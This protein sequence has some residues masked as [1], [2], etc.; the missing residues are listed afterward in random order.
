M[1]NVKIGWIA[2]FVILVSMVFASCADECKDVVCVQGECAEGDCV[3]NTGYEGLDCS[4]PFNAKF[5]GTYTL[6]ESCTTT[7]NDTYDVVVTPDSTNPSRAKLTNLYREPDQL[8]LLIG[9]DG[10]SF[11][12]DSTSVSGGKLVSAGACTS[13]EAGTTINLSYKFVSSSSSPTETCNATL[14]RQP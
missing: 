9:N 10:V 4:V 3:C 7:G 5:S 2:T 11:T 14:T 6:I 13:N 8:I 1:K 12:I